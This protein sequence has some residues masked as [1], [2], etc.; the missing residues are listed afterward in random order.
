MVK[1]EDGTYTYDAGD[2]GEY[3]IYW[4]D[5]DWHSGTI[6]GVSADGKLVCL[7]TTRSI[8]KWWWMYQQHWYESKFVRPAIM[9]PDNRRISGDKLL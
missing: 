8:W 6:V 7:F 1:S 4:N 2:I 9:P 3:V 5:D